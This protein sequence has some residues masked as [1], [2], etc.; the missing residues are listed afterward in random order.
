MVHRG[1]V[2]AAENRKAGRPALL[3]TPEI[4]DHSTDGAG[5]AMTVVGVKYTTA[6]RVAQTAV[7]RVAKLLNKRLAPSR[8]AT[9]VLPGAGIADHE[10]LAIETERA[11]NLQLSIATIRHLIGLYAERSADII[12]L[13]H[14][15]PELVAPLSPTVQTLGAEI[16]YVIRHEMAM[17]LS[18][19]V[20]R[21]TGM[22][23]AGP[24]DAAALEAA[25]ALA[26]QELAWSGERRTQEIAAVQDFYRIAESS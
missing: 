26:A 24:P 2:P 1:I 22:G 12:R 3:S 20:I 17:R 4:Y 18:D 23:A 6:R 11:C 14:E 8:T 5:G 19:I 13:I 25:A 16:V 15:A 21:R 10:A 9:A 7:E